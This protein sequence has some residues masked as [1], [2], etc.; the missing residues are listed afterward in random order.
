MAA[1]TTTT[2]DPLADAEVDPLD[3]NRLASVIGQDRVARLLEGATRTRER[4]GGRRVVNINSTATGGGVAELL[5]VL[6][7]Y[8]R[9]AG[10]ATT[11]LVVHGDPAFFAITKRIHNRLY[12]SPGDDGELGARERRL[13]ERTLEANAE[14][15]VRAVRPGDIA[16][17]HD[18]QPAGL[19]PALVERRAHVIWRCHVGSDLSNE[20]TEQAWE[21]LR[22]YVEPAQ[23]HVFSRASF[24]PPFLDAGTL[25]VI[26]PSIDPFAAKN[27]PLAPTRRLAIL[28]RAGIVAPQDAEP[29]AERRAEVLRD[30]PPLSPATPLVVQISR[31]DRLKDMQG[32]LQGFVEHVPAASG[33][34]LVLAGPA[35]AGVADDPE[36]EAVWTDTAEAWR[37]LTASDRE[38][39]HLVLAPMADVHENA[40]LINALQRQA[41]VVVQKSLAEGFGLTVA[42]A[43]W[44]SRPVIGSAVGGIADQLVDGVSGVLLDDP[45]DL[46]A[47]GQAAAGLVGSPDERR[48]LGRNA[49]RRASTRFLPDRHLLDYAALFERIAS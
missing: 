7:G 24:A 30:G 1:H 12:G 29:L 35:F 42:E 11:W 16:I 6:L 44:K 26:A 32:V 25:T 9:G 19:V 39:V 49:R 3:P 14:S 48:R 10:I 46:E 5:H 8:A 33:A 31:W 28:A 47:F 13:Y 22:R 15:V 40:L 43:M 37:Q 45:H 18:P 21:F 20:W 17:V 38:R 2:R 36:A 34:S 4:L 27:G 23:A 41:A